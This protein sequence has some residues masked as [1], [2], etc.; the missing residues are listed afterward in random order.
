M[1][2]PLQ[3]RIYTEAMAPRVAGFVCGTRRFEK[4][5]AD[6]I[7][8]PDL[9]NYIAQRGNT[10]WLYFTPEDDLV[11]FGSLGAS[12]WGPL[13]G[14]R[15]SLTIIPALAIRSEYQG[16]PDDVEER[17]KFSHQIM[18]DLIGRAKPLGRP[19]LG[20]FVHP[21]NTRAIRLY[22]KFGFEKV[23]RAGNGHDQMM[24]R[25]Q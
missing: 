21:R 19:I 4:A 6:W 2:I 22:V 12:T 17:D 5:M 18:R 11:G 1:P 15:F 20:L 9:L 8:R 23:Q 25:L 10:V 24:L 16:K 7:T 3:A 13:D 14:P